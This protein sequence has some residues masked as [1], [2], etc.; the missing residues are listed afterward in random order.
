VF[1]APFSGT[2]EFTEFSMSAIIWLGIAYCGWTGGH[3]SVDIF[4]GAMPNWMIRLSDLLADILG[5]V[6]FLGLAWTTWSAVAQ[7]RGFGIIMKT[8]IIGLPFDWFK[9][10]IIV[11][12]LI[13]ALGMMLRAVARLG[14]QNRH[15]EA[16]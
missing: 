14:G 5:A 11:M 15:G 3:I 1:N 10:A 6:I 13:T 9:G 12:S 8:N 16:V 7:M 2:W 4:E